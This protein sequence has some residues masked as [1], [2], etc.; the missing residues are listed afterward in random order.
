[1]EDTLDKFGFKKDGIYSWV[2]ES[3]HVVIYFD[4]ITITRLLNDGDTKTLYDGM[5][6]RTQTEEIELI[7]K[8]TK[9]KKI[10]KKVMEL[11]DSTK[12]TR[13]YSNTSL[14]ISNL[15]INHFKYNTTTQDIVC[16]K[17]KIKI[18]TLK[19]YLTG[20]HDFKLSELA[21]ISV[22]LGKAITI[23]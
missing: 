2:N 19:I 14:Y 7:E 4:G 17:L 6:P 18:E 1:M 8:H 10:N 23:K 5:M 20:T 11:L 15:L 21:N 22:L 3:Y 12:S 16:K 13:I 9:L